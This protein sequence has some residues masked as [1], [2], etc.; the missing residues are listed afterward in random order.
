MDLK[1]LIEYPCEAGTLQSTHH[2]QQ[3]TPFTTKQPLRRAENASD[4]DTIYPCRKARTTAL[5]N[6]TTSPP[7][8]TKQP[9][10]PMAKETT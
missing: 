3:K 5:P 7:M 2:R 9:P 8:L 4:R 1:T 10:P 6:C